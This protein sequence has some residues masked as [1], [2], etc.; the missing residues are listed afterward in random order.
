MMVAETVT[1]S[2][3]TSQDVCHYCGVV[4]L[5]ESELEYC[6]QCA[7]EICTYLYATNQAD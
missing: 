1:T 5:V 4:P 2:K 6:A 7:E 3:E